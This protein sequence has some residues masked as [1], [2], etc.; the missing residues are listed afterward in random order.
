MAKNHLFLNFHKK[1]VGSGENNVQSV[2]VSFCLFFRAF[3]KIYSSQSWPT[4]GAN[5]LKIQKNYKSI[6]IGFVF[7]NA[8]LSGTVF[9]GGYNCKTGK[10]KSTEGHKEGIWNK[11]C[12]HH[13]LSD[14]SFVLS[15]PVMISL[16][17]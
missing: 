3:S 14:Y 16:T 2:I 5:N 1:K 4:D 9:G 8:E 10:R 12:K 7:P 17:L 15:T 6:K 11:V 13:K